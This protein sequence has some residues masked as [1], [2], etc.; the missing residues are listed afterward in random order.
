MKEIELPIEVEEYSPLKPDVKRLKK[1]L[2]L[3]IWLILWSYLILM[4]AS[5][6]LVK[7]ISIEEEKQ[8]FKWFFDTPEKLEISQL[9]YWVEIP[10]EIYVIDDLEANAYAL[11]GAIIYVTQWL[12]NEI[13]YEEELIFILGHEM[14]HIENR[15]VLVRVSKQLPFQFILASIWLNSGFSWVSLW[16]FSGNYSSQLAEKTADIWGIDLV[17]SLW[18]NL[19]CAVWF[20]ERN[21]SEDTALDSFFSTHPSN[22]SRIDVIKQSAQFQWECRE[23][24]YKK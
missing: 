8:L 17:N 4:I 22:Q 23:L 24:E 9:S 1:M 10:Y 21:L 20:F 14:A 11:P 5:W 2:F 13:E 12:L 19:S 16:D 6:L 18:W 3:V 15:D 7:S